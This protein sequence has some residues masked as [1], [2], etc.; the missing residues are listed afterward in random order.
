MS[1]PSQ[2]TTP[3]VKPA[4]DRLDSWKE[5]AVYLKPRRDHRPALGEARGD[6]G[7]PA[8][9]R[10]DGLGLRVQFGA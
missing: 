7:P 3:S 6:A 8:P 10:P 9:P 4:E 5:I 2:G 1:E